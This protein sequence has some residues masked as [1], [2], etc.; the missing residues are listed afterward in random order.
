MSKEKTDRRGGSAFAI[1]LDESL[2][3]DALAAVEKRMAPTQRADGA[4]S[5]D[6][7]I[8]LD[9]VDDGPVIEESLEEL[10]DLLDD[11]IPDIEEEIFLGEPA[12]D[13][14]SDGAGSSDGEYTDDDYSEEIFAAPP[15]G[16][17][18]SDAAAPIAHAPPTNDTNDTN[19]NTFLVPTREQLLQMYGELEAEVDGLTESKEQLEHD[20]LQ[21]R[22]VVEGLRAERDESQQRARDALRK[23]GMMVVKARRKDE[24]LEQ[25]HLDI[26]DAQ[27]MMRQR[28]QTIRDFRSTMKEDERERERLRARHTRE[29][30]DA[31][32]FANEK[33]LKNLLPVLDHMEL[34]LTHADAEPDRIREGVDITWKQLLAVLT[35]AGLMSIALEPGDAF[36]PEHQEAMEYVEAPD[37][38]AN[39]VVRVYQR[40][41][42]LAGRLIRAARVSVSAE[43]DVVADSDAADHDDAAISPGGLEE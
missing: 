14:A 8:D 11:G 31:R 37:V 27:S 9:I 19:D 20:L 6:I 1:D 4:P 39:H 18:A 7:E 12:G 23:A 41:Y 38:A 16:S 34:A 15:A 25:L 22:G 3:A 42:L 21:L 26:S 17:P 10:V 28:D 30:E 13:D 32:R 5:D 40:G 33:L 24:Q 2:I 35:R 29:S 43:L 36:D